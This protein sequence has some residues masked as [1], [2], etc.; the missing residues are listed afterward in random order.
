[1][2][3]VARLGGQLEGDQAPTD[4][5]CESKEKGISDNIAIIMGPK[6]TLASGG[7]TSSADLPYTILK[8]SEDW[9]ANVMSKYSIG[10]MIRY[11]S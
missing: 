5:T 9:E 3:T 10:R 7:V 4:F 6:H 8:R 11:Q 1:M 2:F